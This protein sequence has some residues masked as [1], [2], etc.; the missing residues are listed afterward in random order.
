M[1]PEI[2][3]NAKGKTAGKPKPEASVMERNHGR[4]A[5]GEVVVEA[6]SRMWF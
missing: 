3:K 4:E 1:E 6:S 2:V 5:W